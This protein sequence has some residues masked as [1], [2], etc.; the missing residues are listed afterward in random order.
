MEIENFIS[1]GYLPKELPPG[2]NSLDLGKSIN[3]INSE[4]EKEFSKISKEERKK[5][6]SS[7]SCRF[8]YPKN[9]HSRRVL[10][11]PNPLHYS[12]LSS[13]LIEHWTEISEHINKSKLSASKPIIDKKHSRYVREESKTFAEFK[14]RCIEISF[15]RVYQLKL[16]ISNYYPTIYTHSIPWALHGIEN[17]KKSIN[18]KGKEHKEDPLYFWGLCGN[19]IDERLRHSQSNQSIGI[20]IGPDSSLIISEIILSSLDQKL[21]S[22]FPTIKGLRYIDD[23]FIY[24]E[25]E[26]EAEKIVKEFQIILNEFQLSLNES[27]TNIKKFPFEFDSS[28]ASELG[29]FDFRFSSIGYEDKESKKQRTDIKNYFSLAF[30]YADEH[31]K[32]PVLKYAIHPLKNLI[33]KVGV[34]ESNWNY[35]ESLLLKTI[36]IEPAL[37]ADATQIFLTYKDRIDKEKIGKIVSQLIENHLAIGH[38]YEVSWVL[39]MVKELEIQ[40]DLNLGQKV[41]DLGDSVSRI[42]LFDLIDLKLVPNEL[43]FSKIHLDFNSESLTNENWLLVYEL[44][45]KGWVSGYDQIIDDH[46]F[47]RILKEKDISFYTSDKTI[48]PISIPKQEEE[49]WLNYSGEISNDTNKTEVNEPSSDFEFENISNLG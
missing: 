9:R 17:A 2:F 18:K 7:T 27:K 38:H 16:D 11:I 28:W 10:H 32:E 8:T 43:D 4:W 20:P 23:Y 12:K 5:Y 1:K 34:Y 31:Q 33:K 6:N 41:I 3:D 26:A 14:E 49:E 21:S 48:K 46:G 29:K 42:L 47:F 39:W 44:I 30:K 45:K 13:T 22:L 35:F 15:D 40:V 19:E 24:T 25:T 36:L 37:L